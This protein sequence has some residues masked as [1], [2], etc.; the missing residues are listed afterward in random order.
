MVVGYSQA[1]LENPEAALDAAMR[2]CDLVA[3]DPNEYAGFNLDLGR[4]AAISG[5]FDL[6]IES[7]ERSLNEPSWL[8]VAR[9]R[10]DW[11]YDN[12]RQDPRFRRLM[13]EP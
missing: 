3:D 12:L 13:G 5:N 10:Q 2:A 7:I 6:A 8:T 11:R 9:A 4:I 1:V